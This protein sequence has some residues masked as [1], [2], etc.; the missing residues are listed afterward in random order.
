TRC[1]RSFKKRATYSAHGVLPVPPT[2]KFPTLTTGIVAFSI[3]FQ[4][5]SYSRFRTHMPQPYGQ[6]AN[7]RPQRCKLAIKPRFW[8]LTSSRY[9]V[10]AFT[11]G[12]ILESEFSPTRQNESMWNSDLRWDA[13]FGTFLGILISDPTHPRSESFRNVGTPL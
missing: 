6:L 4:P 5:R 7:R 3:D 8:P 1:P 12:A 2:V 9:R 11:L 13:H 10:A